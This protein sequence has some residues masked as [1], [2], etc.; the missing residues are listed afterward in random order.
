VPSQ[1]AV[2]DGAIRLRMDDR[3][4]RYPI[5]IDPLVGI[6]QA[7]LEAGDG[8][9]LD[10]FGFAVAVQGDTALVGA[11]RDDSAR[12]TDAGAAYVFVRSGATW[13]EQ[14]KLEASDGAAE[15]AFGASVALDGDTAIVGAFQRDTALGVNAG[16]AYVFVRSGTTWTEQSRLEA[17]D[18][19]AF[20]S[21]G[22]AV[23]LAGDTVL[24]G[25]RDADAARA[26]RAGATYV[27]TRSG[28]PWSAQAK[29]EASD[30]ADGDAF[31]VA[32]ALDGDTA[33]VGANGDAT[34]RGVA[35]GSAYVFVRSGAAWTEQARLEASDGAEGDVF[36]FSVS[37]SGDT[38][39]VGAL[40]DDTPQGNDAG[41]AYV[42]VRSG[43]MWTEQARIRPSDGATGDFFGYAVSLEGDTALVGAP[44]H[45][46]SRG[47]NVGS[48]YLITRRGT[49]W[50]VQSRIDA[51]DGAAVDQLGTA[52]SLD[53]A[54]ALVGAPFD[55]T[56]RGMDV[57]SAYVFRVGP[58]S[59]EPCASGD[60][61]A[62]GFCVDGVC[63]DGA[64]GGGAGDDCE[65]CSVAAGAATNGSCGPTTGNVCS[66][67]SACTTVDACASGLCAGTGSPCIGGT[68]CSAS[69]ASFTCAPCPAGTASADGTGLTVC[70]PCDAG[71]F[72]SAGATTCAAW[73][74]CAAAEYES[75]APTATRD[76]TCLRCTEC[77]AD[78]RVVTPCGPTSDTVC[79]AAVDAGV[80]A[81]DAGVDAGAAPPAASGGCG[82][83]VPGRDSLPGAGV[84]VV[85]AALVGVL[86]ARRRRRVRV[87][88]RA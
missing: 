15:D 38:A 50:G 55:D 3:S 1:L 44:R 78:E 85:L 28:S 30:G 68:E 34:P 19:T 33:L 62:S 20:A 27:Y 48:A 64:C 26:T 58:G 2:V 71:R 76:R 88:R 51:R 10:A 87:V 53:G 4:A 69:G 12:G 67:G 66:D 81:P 56:T 29:L 57:G 77:R 25:A 5:V 70:V 45:S 8:S 24:V 11:Y 86:G 14:A 16:A 42:F 65:A 80:P 47:T 39:L 7:R 59:G 21:F 49:N 75:V 43:T 31:G 73:S 83:A 79:A 6:E 35:A 32:V 36:G 18:G 72:A 22:A 17:S 84:G 74:M 41:S 61:C 9:A 40:Y 37:L 82:C 60:A 46:T 13:T 23:A 52:V 54:T 63:C